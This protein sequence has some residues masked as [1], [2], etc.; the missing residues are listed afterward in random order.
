MDSQPAVN[1]SWQQAALYCNWLSQQQGLP[2]FYQV[3]DDR[4]VGFNWQSHGYRLPTEAEWAWAAKISPEAGS[5][6]P[7]DQNKLFPWQSNLYPPSEV[8]DNYGDQRGLGIVSFT[9]SGY[10]DGYGVAA[11]V[12][13]YQ[14][15]SKGLYNMSGN[16]S[17]WVNDYYD[18]HPN[19]NQILED[20]RGPGTGQSACGARCQLGQGFAQ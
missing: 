14:P 1:I 4:V 19:S 3:V 7:A 5:T 2:P 9:M 16:V 20:P 11:P 10:D 8:T 18:P 13:S 6:V 17:E 15:N 12:G